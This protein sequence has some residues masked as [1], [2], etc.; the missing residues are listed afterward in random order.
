MSMNQPPSPPP[1]SRET[2]LVAEDD[3]AV[4]ELIRT[5]LQRDGYQVLAAPDGPQAIELLKAHGQQIALAVLDMHMPGMSGVE[6]LLAM[7]K[8]QPGFKALILTG[9]PEYYEAAEL[10]NPV[11]VLLKPIL[12]VELL[13]EIRKAIAAP[14]SP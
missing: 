6:C 13:Q 12:R 14:P 3:P 5:F 4:R 9:S 10:G 8:L 7:K 1:A 11:A 2:I